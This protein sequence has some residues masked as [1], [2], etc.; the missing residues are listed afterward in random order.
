[1]LYAI[2]VVAAIMIGGAFALKQAWQSNA[3]LKQNNKLLEEAR[4][5]AEDNVLF[6][7]N[8]G[9]T[10]D[11]KITA[12]TSAKRATATELDAWKGRYAKAL[13]NPEDRKWADQPIPA[14]V[15]D[16]LRRDASNPKNEVRGGDAASEFV[17]RLREGERAPAGE[18][19]RPADSTEGIGSRLRGLFGAGSNK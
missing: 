1:M 16:S 15:R 4:I 14:A 3:T 8:L 10:K 11:S 5:E 12:L 18:D 6:Q 19:R 17:R 7:Q 9:L 13:E 2:L